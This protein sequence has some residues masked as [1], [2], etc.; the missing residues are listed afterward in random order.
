MLYA[1]GHSTRPID[2]FIAILKA[3]GI[4]CLA[5]IRTVPKSRHNPQYNGDA[6]KRSLRKEKIR[7][8]H[9]KDLGGLRKA[10]PD[11]V[12]KGWQNA[13]FRG[14]ADYMQTPEFEKGVKKLLGLAEKK[15]V[16]FM[17]AEGNPFRCH[18]SLLADALLARGIEVTQ[19]SSRKPGRLHRKTP[20]ARIRGRKVTYPAPKPARA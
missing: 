8:V 14:Y 4:R 15:T 2:A 19:I 3:H 7:Y 9:L 12:N 1:L 6:L 13:S 17:C 11:S 5:D 20:F 16:A 18:R 10:R